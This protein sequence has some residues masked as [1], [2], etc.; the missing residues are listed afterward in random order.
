MHICFLSLIV[1]FV[2]IL[3]LLKGIFDFR[4][5]KLRMAL[6]WAEWLVHCGKAEERDCWKFKVTVVCVRPRAAR[7]DPV[8]TTTC[9][10][11]QS[12]AI[13]R[14]FP[15]RQCHSKLP[16]APGLAIGKSGTSHLVFRMCA[17]L[18][19]GVSRPS[20]G[21]LTSILQNSEVF[22]VAGPIL[23]ASL[24][25]YLTSQGFVRNLLLSLCIGAKVSFSY[26]QEILEG[27]LAVL[28]ESYGVLSCLS[29]FD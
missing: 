21:E 1:P 10:Y 19:H 16:T 22:T 28:R 2:V 13:Q 17:H 26:L 25:P 29:L 11:K 8:S 3:F 5:I 23:S 20:A 4:L 12:K 7:Q 27:T 15:N 14:S 18:A 24:E 6:Q 9:L